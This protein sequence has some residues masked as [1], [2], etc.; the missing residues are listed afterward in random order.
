MGRADGRDAPGV[1]RSTEL[2]ADGDGDEG[3]RRGGAIVKSPCTTKAPRL[4][5]RPMRFLSVEEVDGLAA[6]IHPHHRTL[7]Y[8]LAYGGLRW[9]EAAG[10]R[11]RYVDTVRRTSRIEEQL[12]EV[13][14]GQPMPGQ[15]PKTRAGVRTFTIPAFLAAMLDEHFVDL[16][17]QRAELG[18]GSVGPNDF[19]F[20]NTKGGLL[21]RS[22]FRIN[23][24]L[25]A[26]RKAG[27]EGLRVHDL[28]H[29]AVAFAINLSNAHPKAVQVRFGHSSIQVTYDRY[30]HLFPQMDEDIAQ[31]LDAAYRAARDGANNLA[32]VVK[33]SSAA[34]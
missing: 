9:A 6:G 2:R 4:E 32:S 1:G 10:L 19:V 31:N 12:G 26:V 27:L 15:P 17:K 22:G 5:V 13:D 30:G 18:R 3:G 11:R 23:H 29:T 14:G 8:V 28:R 7:V 24:W 16:E 21:R 34:R 33:V 25:P 20:V